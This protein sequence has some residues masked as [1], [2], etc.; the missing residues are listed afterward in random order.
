ML[1]LIPNSYSYDHWLGNSY[2]ELRIIW[3]LQNNSIKYIV[4]PEEPAII[5]TSQ[6]GIRNQQ[7]PWREKFKRIKIF[8]YIQIKILFPYLKI[9]VTYQ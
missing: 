9:E 5:F 1:I 2:F 7:G 3:L 6:H 4:A 8:Y